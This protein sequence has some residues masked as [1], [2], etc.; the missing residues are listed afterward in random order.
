MQVCETWGSSDPRWRGR[1]AGGQYVGQNHGQMKNHQLLDVNFIHKGRSAG[2]E[3]PP[4][5]FALKKSPSSCSFFMDF[6]RKL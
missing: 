3:E 6:A 4:G 5:F 2:E 1:I